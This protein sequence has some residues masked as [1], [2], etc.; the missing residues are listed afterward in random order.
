MKAIPFLFTAAVLIAACNSTKEKT[1]TD[2]T[3]NSEIISGEKYAMAVNKGLQ[4]DTM[5]TS[6]ARSSKQNIAGNNVVIDYYAP[7]VRGRVI[8]GGLV[9]YGQV[10]VT[11]AHSATKISFDKDISFGSTN[12][13][14]GSYAIFTIPGKGNWTFILNSN[15]QQHLADDYRQEQDIIRIPV[16][17]ET[18]KDTVQRL[19]YEI[20]SHGEGAGSITILWETIKLSVPFNVKQVAT[21]T[22][23]APNGESKL[24]GIKTDNKKDPVCYMPVS[25]GITDTAIYHNKVYGF[26][27]AECKR[28]FVADP[29]N[30]LAKNIQ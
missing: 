8:W 26:C 24:T 30:Y 29:K 19:T 7:G 20:K 17:P 21:T 1:A 12:V 3:T 23:S 5:R 14:A 11:G 27:S 15:F 25:A 4:P 2:A 10:W 18:V 6:V 9:P 22:H 16:T 28:L 13:P